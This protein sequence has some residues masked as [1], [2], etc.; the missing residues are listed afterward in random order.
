MHIP[1]WRRA[2]GA[3]LGKRLVGEERVSQ[4]KRQMALLKVRLEKALHGKLRT[5]LFPTVPGSPG[6]FYKH[7][8]SVKNLRVL[9][10]S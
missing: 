3:G 10:C 9:S 7:V 8:D 5:G 4:G 2:A 6:R 1:I